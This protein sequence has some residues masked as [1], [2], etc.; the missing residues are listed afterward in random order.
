M[1]PK[2]WGNIFIFQYTGIALGVLSNRYKK[3]EKLIKN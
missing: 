1:S 3:N 2:I